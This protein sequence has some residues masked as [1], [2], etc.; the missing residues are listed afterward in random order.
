MRGPA[1]ALPTFIP[2]C[3][4]PVSLSLLSLLVPRISGCNKRSGVKS[5][6]ADSAPAQ[7]CSFTSSLRLLRATLSCPRAAAW[8][9]GL[10]LSHILYDFRIVSKFPRAQARSRDRAKMISRA[11]LQRQRGLSPRSERDF[12]IGSHRRAI[13]ALASFCIIYG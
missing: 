3:P 6:L 13:L 12:S 8:F 1:L 5:T 10:E 7:P 2:R 11:P 9:S 4:P